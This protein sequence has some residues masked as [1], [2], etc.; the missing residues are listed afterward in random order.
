MFSALIVS[1]L[2]LASV[3]GSGATQVVLELMA[4][5]AV[6][7]DAGQRTRDALPEPAAGT[8]ATPSLAVLASTTAALPPA[9]IAAAPAAPPLAAPAAQ[10]PAAAATTTEAPT[11]EPA[12]AALPSP[13]LLALARDTPTRLPDGSIF[14]PMAIQRLIGLRTQISHVEPLAESFE[15]AGRIVTSRDVAA[16]VQPVQIGVI[17]APDG[18]LPRVG[19]RVERG[20]L[21]AYQR[22]LLDAARRADLDAKIADLRSQIQ[23]GEQRIDRLHEVWLIRYRQSK[24]DAVA[25][26]LASYRRQLRIFE[27]LLTDRT[28]IRAETAGIISRVNFVVGQIVEPQTALFEIVD[29]SR[30]WVEAAAFDPAAAQDIGSA[31]AVTAEGQVLR[32]RFIGGG[33]T[34]QNQSLPLQFEVVGTIP[35]AQVGKPVTVL[36]TRGHALRQGIRVPASALVRNGAGETVVWERLSAESFLSRAVT[37]APLDGTTVD[38]TGGLTANMRIVTAGSAMLSQVR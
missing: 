8:I 26:E 28:E 12:D 18:P 25:A 29:P 31:Q 3:A 19:M 30:L 4:R 17:E 33:M 2:A 7:Q 34:L 1:M 32:L 38:I 15:I 9:P 21:L 27:A 36:I 23:M 5:S 24:I 16:I 10:P 35:A 13:T 11:T 20:Q 6:E 22:P 37:A 14:L